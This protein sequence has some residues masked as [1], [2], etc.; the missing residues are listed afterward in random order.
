MKLFTA[1]LFCA[2]AVQAAET[3]LVPVVVTNRLRA[4]EWYREVD[5]KLYNTQKSQMWFLIRGTVATGD[6]GGLI[7][8]TARSKHFFEELSGKNRRWQSCE[9]FRNGNGSHEC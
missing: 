3:S 4:V 6:N 5:G 1:I 7:V 9:S 8:E 2:A